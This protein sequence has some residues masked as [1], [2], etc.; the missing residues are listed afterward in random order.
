MA[1]LD[2]DKMSPEESS[3]I[4]PCGIYCGAC[5]PFLG[6]S[7]ELARELFRIIDGFNIQDVA[8]IVLGLER[9]KMAEFLSILQQLS[10]A[11]RCPGCLAGG[12]NPACPMK[13]CAGGKGYLTCAEC[14]KLPCSA[15]ETHKDDDPMSA[16]AILQMIT[17]RYA[18]WNIENLKRIREVGYRA[19]IDEMQAKVKK[20]F[21]TSD[22]ISDEMVL[23]E[24]LKKL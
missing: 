3:L 17:R 12:G 23:T 21:L 4:A 19:F 6:K 11:K 9:E 18:G 13:A 14:E 7:K 1:K 2:R 15:D 8:P 10:E 20:G 5:D 22:V 24:F 16:P